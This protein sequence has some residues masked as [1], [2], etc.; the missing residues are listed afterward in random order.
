MNANTLVTIHGY[1]GDQHQIRNALSVHESHR[2]SIVIFSPEDSPIRKMG[3]HICR[4]VGR[5]AYTGPLSLT[6]QK[7]HMEEMLK[8][9]FQF[10]LAND[11][12]SVCLSPE[13]P[14]Y[15][16]EH[17][18]ILWSNEVSDMMHHRAPGYP[19]PRL[20]FQPPYFMSRQVI[21]RLL[22]VIDSVPVDM[23]TPFI[24]WSMMAWA[25]ASGCPHSNYR[26]GASYPTTNSP[27]GF[28]VMRRVVRSE[29]KIFVHSIKEKRV[30]DALINDRQS[31]LKQARRMQM[32]NN[33]NRVSVN[34]RTKR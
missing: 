19:W 26:D 32:A 31:F 3:P 15:V 28:N 2:C 12:D 10:F 7:L 13:I 34:R 4:G 18:E 29:G 9:P 1:S 14:R 22:S 17:P 23:Q 16:Y 24:D 6:R 27:E 30:L 11:A 21:E 20:A 33:N 5:R 25:I 8:Y